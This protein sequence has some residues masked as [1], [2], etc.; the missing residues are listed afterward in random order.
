MEPLMDDLNIQANYTSAGEHE[1]TAERNN[2]T[3]GECIRM[4]YHSLPYAALPPTMTK[5]SAMV[6]TNQLN[7]FPAKGGI[8][9]F[10]SPHVIMTQKPLDY[11]KHFQISFGAYVQGNQDNYPTNTHSSHMIDGIYLR[12][13]CNKQGGH[14]LM[15][16]ITRR[17]I[18]RNIVIELPAT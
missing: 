5:H 9:K 6:V 2:R 17:V 8:S 4:A 18:T 13:Q 12:P 7:Y 3:I 11:N 10:L 15:D 1:I 16:I 14:E